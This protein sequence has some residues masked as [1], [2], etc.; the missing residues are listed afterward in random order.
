MSNTYSGFIFLGLFILRLLAGFRFFGLIG[1]GLFGLLGGVRRGRG[2][3]GGRW[4]SRGGTPGLRGAALAGRGRM[5][6]LP[7]K[8]PGAG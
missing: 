3:R 7:S 1:G 6:A 2:G 5:Q 8:Q 4:G